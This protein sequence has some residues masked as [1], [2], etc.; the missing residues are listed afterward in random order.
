M[1]RVPVPVDPAG[2]QPVNHGTQPHIHAVHH[3]FPFSHAEAAQKQQEAMSAARAQALA[4]LEATKQNAMAQ[5][6]PP[7]GPAGGLKG[8]RGT[9]ETSTSGPSF[10]HIMHQDGQPLRV[11][12]PSVPLGFPQSSPMVRDMG[13][14]PPFM[15]IPFGVP[16]G[17]S[18]PRPLFVMRNSAGVGMGVGL[19]GPTGVQDMAQARRPS[20]APNHMDVASPEQRRK[21]DRSA[22]VE[23]IEDVSVYK[24]SL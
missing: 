15:R 11:S 6:A 3:D 18:I 21:E 19:G 8:P 10:G 17:A 1:R 4:Q 5:S 13:G 9:Y 20:P 22:Y 14:P 16:L 7:A 2:Q 23:T 12:G 24:I